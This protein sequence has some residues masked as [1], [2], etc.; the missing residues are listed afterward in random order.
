ME[1]RLGFLR[2]N[3]GGEDEQRCKEHGKQHDL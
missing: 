2:S 1:G 3:E